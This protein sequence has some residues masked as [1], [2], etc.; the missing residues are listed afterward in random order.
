MVIVDFITERIVFFIGLG[1]MGGAA[2]GYWGCLWRGQQIDD[3]MKYSVLIGL[4]GL[5]VIFLSFCNP[6]L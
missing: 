4:L 5:A 3:C 2:L 1:I 6:R